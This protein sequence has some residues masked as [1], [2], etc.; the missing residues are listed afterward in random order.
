MLNFLCVFFLCFK[1]NGTVVSLKRD[2]AGF[3]TQFLF[4]CPTDLILGGLYSAEKTPVSKS[5]NKI[6]VKHDTC[7]EKK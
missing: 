1:T 2:V 7:F 4:D 6:K 5:R 3:F